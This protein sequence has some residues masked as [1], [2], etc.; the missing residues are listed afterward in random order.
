MRVE[1]HWNRELRKGEGNY[2]LCV[3]DIVWLKPLD[4]PL[5]ATL[6]IFLSL[7]RPSLP[8][9]PNLALFLPGAGQLQKAP[10]ALNSCQATY[11][12]VGLS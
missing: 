3:R 10:T 11:V 12:H 6:E 1:S 5:A 2:G 4:K 9:P 7:A 8:T